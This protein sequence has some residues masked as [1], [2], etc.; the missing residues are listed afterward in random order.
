MNI[1]GDIV[2]N[3]DSIGAK[4]G[5]TITYDP[6]GQVTS[7]QPLPDD[8]TGNFDYGW[9]GSKQRQTEHEASLNT[10]EMGAR[11]YV[12]GL[13]RFLEVDPVEGGSANDYDYCDGDPINCF[14]LDGTWGFKNVKKFWD[15][16]RTAILVTAVVVATIAA[17]AVSCASIA[18]CG[19]GAAIAMQGVRTVAVRAA[20]AGGNA[21]LRMGAN[22]AVR[23]MTSRASSRMN[24]ARVNGD[25]GHGFSRAMD[26]M[27]GKSGKWYVHRGKDGK[28]VRMFRSYGSLN[29]RSGYFEYMM[30]WGRI[31]HR[32]FRSS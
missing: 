12:P 24:V 22:P 20:V 9:L 2:A 10:I 8:E 13:G 15:D 14:D 28:A 31:N 32:V 18:G 30:K 6:F 1:H 16:H 23:G 17:A 27:I 4:Q 7:T 19:V 26:R 5:N 21:A 11:Q 3:A 25:A 29:G